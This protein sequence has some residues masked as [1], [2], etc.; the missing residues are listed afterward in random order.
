MSSP[1]G[2]GACCPLP[3]GS[4]AA[5]LEKTFLPLTPQP[6]LAVTYD[7]ARS[8]PTSERAYRP[9]PRPCAQ[10]V[11][12]PMPQTSVALPSGSAEAQ[13][14]SRRTVSLQGLTPTT[15]S[16]GTLP[17]HSHGRILSPQRTTDHW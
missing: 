11:R 10:D 9:V 14:A 4:S 12:V 2:L 6:P 8:P 1:L 16:S 3:V 5:K 17:P 7:M 13:A 15:D